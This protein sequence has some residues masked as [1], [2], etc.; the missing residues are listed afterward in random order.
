MKRLI[1]VLLLFAGHLAASQAE[2]F[3]RAEVVKAINLVS[4]LPRSTRAVPGDIIKG[5]TGLKT[6][7]TRGLNYSSRT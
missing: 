5:N 7:V 1:L 6:E 2:P 3:E 4:L